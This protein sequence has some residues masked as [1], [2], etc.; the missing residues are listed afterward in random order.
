MTDSAGH[1][2]SAVVTISADISISPS[3]PS[4]APN[5][6]ITFVATG[7]SGINYAWTLTGSS[8]GSIIRGSGLYTAGPN[9][10][11]SDLITV[12]DSLGTSFR[13]RFFYQGYA[14]HGDSSV[15]PEPP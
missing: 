6:T 10:N 13:P 4:V 15:P 1:T 8:G 3:S 14:I 2:A 12:T 11:S 5:G 7:G 9:G